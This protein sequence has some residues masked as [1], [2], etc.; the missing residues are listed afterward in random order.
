MRH[1]SSCQGSLNQLP[2]C[3]RSFRHRLELAKTAP[4]ALLVSA[5]LAPAVQAAPPYTHRVLADNLPNPRG[6]LLRGNELLVSEAGS[7]GPAQ[8]GAVNCVTG[9]AGDTL[10]SGTTGA[11]GSWNLTTQT[12]ARVLAGLPSL[13]KATGGE[14]TGLADLTSGG[15]TGL[16]G[17]FG[18]GA[19][20][21]AL[22]P[23]LPGSDLFGRVVSIDLPNATLQPRANLA[24]YEQQNNPDGGDL[25]SN[26]YALQMKGG[27]LLATDAG[28]NTLL[29]IDP[30]PSGA[31]QGFAIQGAYAFP[32]TAVPPQPFPAPPLASAVPTG[33]TV[34]AATDELLIGQFTGFPFVPGSAEVYATTGVTPPAST[35]SGFSMITDVAAAANGDVYVLEYATNFFA[36][37]GS[38]GIW[39]VSASGE[40][41]R[42]IDGL[43]NPTSLALGA[44]G[45]IYVTNNADGL[46]GELR[47]YRPV[48][49][50]LPLL[51]AALAWQQARRL[52]R[53]LPA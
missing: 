8:P 50:P 23:T 22:T 9:G 36:P 20:P 47:E 41:L 37:G 15:P 25:I 40:R 34:K 53:R 4:V 29:S 21:L 17:V 13:A 33:L 7:G 16:L 27:T 28:G 48:P 14:G 26:P 3:Q 44:D 52:R 35:L 5:V 45:A 46:Q 24:A 42:I 30:T 49:A 10:C 51:G 11:I 1:H 32:P 6:L 19:N 18:F 43:T 2:R 12:Y 38:G 39:R 31:N